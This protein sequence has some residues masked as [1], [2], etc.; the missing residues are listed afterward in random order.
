MMTQTHLL[1]GAAFALPFRAKGLAPAALLGAALPDLPMYVFVVVARF[2]NWSRHDMW[3]DYYWRD[4]LQIPMGWV[5]SIPVY[6]MILVLGLCI[7]RP[8][9]WGFAGA[10]LLHC[11]SDLLLHHNDGHMHFYPFS[12]FRFESPVSYWD[13]RHHADWWRPIEMG[14]GLTFCVLL[15][16]R[17]RRWWQWGLVGLAGLSYVILPLMWFWH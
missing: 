3:R 11:I 13:S 14:M 7:K 9:L 4:E 16:R 15:A 10:A 6:A 1:M 2:M 17:Y 5:N 12:T 8:W